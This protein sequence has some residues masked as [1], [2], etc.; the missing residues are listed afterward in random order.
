MHL[1]F[2]LLLVLFALVGLPPPEAPAGD[3]SRVQMEFIGEGTPEEEGGGPPAAE[4][5]DAAPVS[6]THLDVYKRQG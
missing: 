3:E 4:A 2:V 1:L 5:A 6:Y